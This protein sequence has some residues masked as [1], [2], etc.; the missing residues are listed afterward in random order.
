MMQNILSTLFSTRF[1]INC[2][3]I[4]YNKDM[5]NQVSEEF[6]KFLNSDE[7]ESNIRLN[8]DQTFNK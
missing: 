8:V 1:G 5:N 4:K 7:N 3:E 6:V 2:E